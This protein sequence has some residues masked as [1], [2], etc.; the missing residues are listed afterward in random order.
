MENQL[1]E[2]MHNLPEM[3]NFTNFDIR[4]ILC[5]INTYIHI[6]HTLYQFYIIISCHHNLSCSL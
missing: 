2:Y 3:G 6:A 4:K 5:G 1:T